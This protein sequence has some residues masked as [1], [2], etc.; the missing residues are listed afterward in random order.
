MARIL[1]IDDDPTVRALVSSLLEARGHSIVVAAEGQAGMAA[2]GGTTIDLVVTDIVMPGQEGIS[3]IGAIRR[4]DR[5]VPILA[6]SGSSTVGR[7]GGHLDA[8]SVMGAS[9]TLTKPLVADAL[10][11]TVERLLAQPQ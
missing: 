4:L 11:A 10:I 5:T 9:A 2:F 6:I 8:A 1:V 7:Y 3:V